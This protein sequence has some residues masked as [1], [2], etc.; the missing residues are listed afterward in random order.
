MSK[1]FKRP[2]AVFVVGMTIAVTAMA[3]EARAKV[4]V[5]TPH[6]VLEGTANGS[7]HRGDIILNKG[8]RGR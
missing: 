7:S 8:L 2:Y 1:H 5:C 4:L 6:F 3:F